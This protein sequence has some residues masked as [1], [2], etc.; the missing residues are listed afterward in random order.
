MIEILLHLNTLRNSAENL[1]EMMGASY[2][3]SGEW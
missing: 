3:N 1:A 2:G